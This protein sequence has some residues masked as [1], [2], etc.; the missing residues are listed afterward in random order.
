MYIAPLKADIPNHSDSSDSDCNTGSNTKSNKRL[1]ENNIIVISDNE[2]EGSTSGQNSNY[3][4]RD[5]E[6]N[7]NLWLQSSS[8]LQK[9]VENDSFSANE[10]RLDILNKLRSSYHIREGSST[11]INISNRNYICDDILNWVNHAQIVDL[12]KNPVVEIG[13]EE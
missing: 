12:I 3:S 13:D 6:S 7:N 4:Y 8:S 10:F 1:N 5:F 9:Q 11:I 2:N